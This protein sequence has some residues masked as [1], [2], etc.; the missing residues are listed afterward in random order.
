MR[1]VDVHFSCGWDFLDDYKLLLGALVVPL[2]PARDITKGDRVLLC[3][4]FAG[5]QHVYK[6]PA[7]IERLGLRTTQGEHGVLVRFPEELRGEVEDT[8]WAYAKGERK[9][10]E[11]RIEPPG[12]LELIVKHPGKDDAQRVVAKDISQ[13]GCKLECEDGAFGKDEEVVLTWTKGR[14]TGKVK[15]SDGAQFGVAFDA[16]LHALHVILSGDVS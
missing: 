14:T 4:R 13:S 1:P 15:W 11:A 8:A 3:C 6:W 2:P 5:D 16:P 12:A 10:S 9:R 7:T